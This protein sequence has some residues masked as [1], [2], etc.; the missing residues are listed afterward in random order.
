MDSE[1]HRFLHVHHS[2]EMKILFIHPPVDLEKSGLDTLKSSSPSLGL[3][4]LASLARKYGHQVKFMDRYFDRSELKE[5]NPDI[6]A[7]TAMTVEFDSANRIAGWIKNNHTARVIIGGNHVS[8]V[9]DDY[10]NFDWVCKGEGEWKFLDYI[11]ANSSLYKSLDDF[12]F[13]AFDLI[14]WSKYRLSPMG[15]TNSKSI[16]L[17]TSRGCFGRCTF[18]SRSVFGNS[19]RYNS[20][21]YILKMMTYVSLLYGIRDFLFYDDLFVGNRKRLL[22]FCKLVH[23]KGFTWSC[24]SRVDVLDQPTLLHMRQAGCWLIEF[25]IE[26]GSQKVLDRMQKNIT[27]DKILK[28]INLTKSVGIITKGNFILGHPGDTHETIKETIEFACSCGLD[29]IQHT[30]FSPLPG[31]ED[32]KTVARLDSW[33]DYTTLKA[34]YTPKDVSKQDLEM[35]SKTL[36]KRFYFQPSKWWKFYKI[37]GVKRLWKAIIAFLKSS[38]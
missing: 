10:S 3:L 24:C 15:T 1:A 37:L 18:C 19:Y 38:L 4:G 36:W 5:F 14:D 9:Q 25:G 29:F 30:F 22:E 16:G 21:N 28:A 26:S 13:P 8:S 17:V 35:Y 2:K 31:S 32:F 34:H 12:P 23:G 6:V 27:I 7:I 33:R 11:G 20:P